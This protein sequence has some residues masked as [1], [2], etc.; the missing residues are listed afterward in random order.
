[1]NDARA[2]VFIGLGFVAM[3]GAVA[4]IIASAL[5]MIRAGDGNQAITFVIAVATAVVAVGLV[6]GLVYVFVRA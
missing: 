1:M 5:C 3:A 6:F 4:L 2:W